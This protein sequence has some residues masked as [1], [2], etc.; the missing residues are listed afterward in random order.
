[1]KRQPFIGS[2]ASIQSRVTQQSVGAFTKTRKADDSS[3]LSPCSDC[4]LHYLSFRILH[5][6]FTPHVTISSRLIYTLHERHHS[7]SVT[8]QHNPVKE[9][10][11]RAATGCRNKSMALAQYICFAAAVQCPDICTHTITSCFLYTIQMLYDTTCL[12]CNGFTRVRAAPIS[13][14]HHRRCNSTIAKQ[15]PLQAI[16]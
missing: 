11:V 7:G 14:I 13:H 12:A 6:H 9:H 8:R 5:A 10:V 3:F 16:Q 2:G 15:L 4:T 1:M